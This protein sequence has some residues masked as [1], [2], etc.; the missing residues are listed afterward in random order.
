MTPDY[1]PYQ[2]LPL[3]AKVSIERLDADSELRSNIQ[4]DEL[5][6]A[7]AATYGEQCDSITRDSAHH[8]C[9]RR[10]G[11]SFSF[12]GWRQGAPKV[13]DIAI[14]KS[15]GARFAIQRI[16]EESI[17]IKGWVHTDEISLRDFA[18]RYTWESV[19]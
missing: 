11:A 18:I 3:W 19:K 14:L 16:D 5:L 12:I 8:I 7:Y 15:N 17:L 4:L 6:N 9:S 10:F 1:T 13:G 2:Y